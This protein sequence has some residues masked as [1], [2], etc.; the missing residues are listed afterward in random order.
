MGLKNFS[1]L[2]EFLVALDSVYEKVTANKDFCTVLHRVLATFY[3][4]S[5]F[6]LLE[7]DSFGTLEIKQL[8]FLTLKSKLGHLHV[9]PRSLKTFSEKFRLI[10]VEQQQLPDI[11]MVYSK[12]EF[13]CLNWTI[14][15]VK[16]K[17]CVNSR[18]MK[19]SST[20]SCTVTEPSRS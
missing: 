10:S 16:R 11:E 3:S 9:V 13:F 6:V 5:F 15:K 19:S 2:T 8:L 18:L 7:S 20:W 1:E 12:N 4:S 14:H 17:A